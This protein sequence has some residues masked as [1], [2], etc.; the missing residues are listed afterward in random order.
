[1]KYTAAVRSKIIFRRTSSLLAV[2]D[3]S[4]TPIARIIVCVL[5]KGM[6]RR[7]PLELQCSLYQGQ[8]GNVHPSVHGKYKTRF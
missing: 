2:C 8:Q 1:M 5:I 4:D 6:G 3:T 7:L